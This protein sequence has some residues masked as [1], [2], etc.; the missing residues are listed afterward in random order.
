MNEYDQDIRA[1]IEFALDYDPLGLRAYS[2]HYSVKASCLRDYLASCSSN[3]T[4]LL[5][6]NEYFRLVK[7]L[8]GDSNE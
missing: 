6:K 8:L 4:T 5:D 1:A 2:T 3:K 7:D